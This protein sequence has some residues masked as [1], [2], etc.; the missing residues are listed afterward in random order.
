MGF[1]FASLKGKRFFNKYFVRYCL[2]VINKWSPKTT[3]KIL[4]KHHL[5][6]LRDDKTYVNYIKYRDFNELNKETDTITQFDYFC[7]II[8][9]APCEQ[10]SL[11]LCGQRRPWSDC[12]SAQSDQGLYCPL[13]ESLETVRMRWMI[14]ICAFWACSKA[15]FCL[16]RSIYLSVNAFLQRTRTRPQ[17]RSCMPVEKTLS[18]LCIQTSLLELHKLTDAYYNKTDLRI[19]TPDGPHWQTSTQDLVYSKFMLSR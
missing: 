12:A 1:P 15:L 7:R 10:V 17:K 6:S 16:T 8:F 5:I 4:I 13:E 11:H 18:S 3:L 19:T 14:W 2:S 9:A